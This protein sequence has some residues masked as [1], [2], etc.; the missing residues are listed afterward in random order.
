MAAAPTLIPAAAAVNSG[1]AEWEALTLAPP[2]LDGTMVVEFLAMVLLKTS[3][4]NRGGGMAVMTP[5]V[6]VEETTD[7]DGAALA[8]AVVCFTQSVNCLHAHEKGGALTEGRPGMMDTEIPG[9]AVH[10]TSAMFE[11]CIEVMIVLQ[12]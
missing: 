8:V 11:P 7:W 1:G 12:I 5:G 10:W 9:A 4:G 3:V 6:L 2:V